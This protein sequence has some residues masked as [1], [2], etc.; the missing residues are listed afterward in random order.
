VDCFFL[1]AFF[2]RTAFLMGEDFFTCFEAWV[3]D[4]VRFDFGGLDFFRLL[5]LFFFLDGMPKVYHRA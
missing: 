5:E 2:G 1:A 3:V 4:F